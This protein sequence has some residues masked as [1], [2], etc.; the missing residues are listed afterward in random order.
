MA[1]ATETATDNL[2]HRRFSPT[3]IAFILLIARGFAALAMALSTLLMAWVLT[4]E[5][6]GIALTLVS[7]AMLASIL[8]SLNVES[9]A[10]RFVMAARRDKRADYIHGFVHFSH[11]VI[12]VLSPIV[13]IGFFIA[14]STFVVKDLSITSVTIAAFLIP[15]LALS[16]STARLAGALNQVIRGGLPQLVL[17]PILVLSGLAIAGISGLK[18]TIEIV[19][20]LFL[21]GT[22]LTI[23]VQKLLL[24]SIIEPIKQARIDD[25]NAS[26]W[27]VS[28]FRLSPSLLFQDLLRD[29]ILVLSAFGLSASDAGV[30][31]VCLAIIMVPNLALIAI[32]MGFGPQISSAMTH[33]RK[34]QLDDL[35]K[36]SACLRLAS[37]T[38][39]VILIQIFCVS[40]LELFGPEYRTG[41]TAL[42]ILCLIPLLKALSGNPILLLNIAGESREILKI[43]SAGFGLLAVIV[44]IAAVFAGTIGAAVSAAFGFGFVQYRFYASCQR[45]D[46]ADPSAVA[47]LRST[48]DVSASA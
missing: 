38:S 14:V 35:L 1:I 5:D 46:L 41:E 37:V 42:R 31:A 22:L 45:S 19:L 2:H 26:E 9:G 4:A 23:L 8:V 36:Q 44:P 10:M 15:A 29:L 32:E 21:A 6:I 13:M 16:R 3:L 40:I 34:Q 20:F 39:T 24:S 25:T 12:L 30:F 28:G 7:T 11:R 17:R 48:D 33:G 47:L 18:L 27:V 43:T